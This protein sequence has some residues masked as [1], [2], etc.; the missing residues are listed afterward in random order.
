MVEYTV[1]H[2]AD[3]SLVQRDA[4]FL[5]VIVVPQAHVDLTVIS[6]IVAV[7]VGFEQR[8]EIDGIDAQFLQMG[9]PFFYLEDALC[10]YPVILKW[11]AAEP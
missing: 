7:G 6:R 8:G 1:Q 2:D 5:K 11:R 3:A 4:D 9:N 10:G